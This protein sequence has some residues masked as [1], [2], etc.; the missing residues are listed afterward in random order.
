VAEV[1]AGG[2]AA[3][4]ILT[5]LIQRGVRVSE[6]RQEQVGLEDVFMQVTKGDLA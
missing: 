4:N 1:A 6:F 2:E 3:A 5:A